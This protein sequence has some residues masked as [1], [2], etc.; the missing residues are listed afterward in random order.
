M[1]RLPLFH[2]VSITD[3]LKEKSAHKT[4]DVTVNNLL[5]SQL[6]TKFRK[7]N[8]KRVVGETILLNLDPGAIMES[9]SH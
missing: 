6:Q 2:L 9:G 8:L 5:C 7:S 3:K 4:T 1:A